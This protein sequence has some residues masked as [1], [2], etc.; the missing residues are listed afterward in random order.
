[1]THRHCV[2]LATIIVAGCATSPE[3]PAAPPEALRAPMP[4]AAAD[5]RAIATA[6]AAPERTTSDRAED[7]WR[8]P[9]VVMNF[10]GVRPG[11]HIIDVLAA[12]GY[13]SELLARATGPQGKVI[14]Y[15][16]PPYARFA[17]KKPELRFADGRLP[18][19]EQVTSEVP[20][21]SLTPNSLDAALFILSYHD[22]YWR[23][24]E[25]GWEQTD[26]PTLLR[27]LHR[28]LKPNGV[29]VVQD[30]AAPA[31]SDVQR[32]A[33]KLHRIDP[34]RVK[35]DFAAAGFR[36]DD[37]NEAFAHPND[38]LAT[39]VFDPA[40]RRQTQQFLFRFVK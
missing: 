13:Y 4:L 18:N 25:G 29:V 38:D 17:G 12:G 19:V 31:G 32:T 11:M 30:H 15:N 14:A 10:M 7:A 6:I 21:L 37:A 3:Q 16:N 35:Q 26:A 27:A 20:E 36:F 1:M 9:A 28:A 5:M 24:T 34:E 23:P 2:V 33:D 22:L 39:P 8:Q 40:V